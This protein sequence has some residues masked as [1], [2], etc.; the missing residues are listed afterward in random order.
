MTGVHKDTVNL[1]AR[2]MR[3]KA[4]YKDP[5]MLLKVNKTDM[6]GTMEA[7][8]EYLRSCHGAVQTPLA[9]I[10]RKTMIVQTY[11]DYTKY[12]TPENKMITKM[13][14]LP[15]DKN[16]VLL[17]HNVHSAKEHIDNRTLYDIFDQ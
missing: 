6:A 14:H 11:D 7:I 16:K 8:K 3:L 1:L 13:L 2:Q 17:E 5:Y 10:L 12:A 9:N 15:P 4:D